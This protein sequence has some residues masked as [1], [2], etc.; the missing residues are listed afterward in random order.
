MSEEEQY[1]HTERS[2][3]K[4]HGAFTQQGLGSHFLLQNSSGRKTHC[5]K[6]DTSKP[7]ERSQEDSPSSQGITVLL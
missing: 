5:E 7:T 3:D 2:K 6:T 1:Q 4:E